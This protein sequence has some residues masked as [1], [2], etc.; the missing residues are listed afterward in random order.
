[1]STRSRIGILN[2]D[3]TVTSIY[4]HHDGY[5]SGVGFILIN[6]YTDEDEIYELMSLGDLSSLDEDIDSCDAYGRDRGE[7]DV[8]AKAFESVDDYQNQNDS[9]YTYLFQEGGWYVSSNGDDFEF[10]TKDII[11]DDQ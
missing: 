9:S 8:E 4:C 3:A 2:E 1:M 7:D 5:P 11:E 6:C 10:L